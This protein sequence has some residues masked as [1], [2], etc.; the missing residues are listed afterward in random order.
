MTAA[1]DTLLA[2]ARAD[3]PPALAHV[4]EHAHHALHLGTAN[5]WM[6][7]LA[8]C[9]DIL[10]D[11]GSGALT[12]REYEPD[13]TVG[14]SQAFDAAISIAQG[15]TD[16]LLWAL[17]HPAGTHAC[18]ECKRTLPLESWRPVEPAFGA[19]AEHRTRVEVSA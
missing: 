12:P 14:G 10:D 3:D 5:T 15:R 17:T 2:L 13:L 9:V 8:E 1:Y 16:E 11:L 6:R 19:C 18:A 4:A 7:D